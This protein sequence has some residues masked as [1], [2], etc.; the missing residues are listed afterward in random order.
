[1]LPMPSGSTKCR[2]H[3]IEKVMTS[4]IEI[5]LWCG[6]GMPG[7]VVARRFLR[8]VEPDTRDCGQCARALEITECTQVERWICPD[9]AGEW[10]LAET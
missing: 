6:G 4:V 10:G 2:T 5:E 3:K 8:S 1:M 7:C 9:C